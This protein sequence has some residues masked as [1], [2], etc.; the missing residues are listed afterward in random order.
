MILDADD[1]TALRLRY[2]PH[3]QVAAVCRSHEELRAECDQALERVAELERA[4]ITESGGE[5]R[6]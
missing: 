3:T 2:G 5:Q 1:I 6:K 4:I